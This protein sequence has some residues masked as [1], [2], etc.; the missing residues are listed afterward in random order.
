MAF[1]T[2]TD[3]KPHIRDHK[4]QM[5]IDED[6]SLIDQ[7]SAIA[8]GTIRNALHS[9]FDVDAIFSATGGDRDA[10][11]VWWGVSLA[12]WHLYGRIPD[13]LVP[14]RVRKNYDDAL[15]ALERISDGKEE[16]ALPRKPDPAQAGAFETKFRWGSL[17]PRSH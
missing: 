12:L 3:F 5:V 7:V 10:V 8:V 17:P 11:V 1:L 9:R 16:S 14:E 2:E 13:K 4:L 6:A 15:I